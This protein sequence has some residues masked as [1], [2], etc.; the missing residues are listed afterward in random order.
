MKVNVRVGWE[1]NSS[2][3]HS[4][5]IT[6][7][8][9]EFT[10]DDVI[11]SW[12][13]HPDGRDKICYSLGYT[14]HSYGRAPFDLLTS[15]D[16][17]LSYI[18][19]SICSNCSRSEAD[20]RF[21]VIEDTVLE[22]FRKEF[23]VQCDYIKWDRT[24]ASRW[25]YV[26]TEEECK[27]I[28]YDKTSY[29]TDLGKSKDGKQIERIV[30][31]VPDYGGIEDGSIGLIQQFMKKYKVSIRDLLMKKRYAIVVDGDEYCIFDKIKEAGLIKTDNIIH[32]FPDGREE[33]EGIY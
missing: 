33:S 23:D 20:R 29:K 18:V 31:D 16:D 6:K 9:T 28:D 21:K 24:V 2:S 27:D 11:A 10:R 7:D 17:K 14:E 8:K 32:E 1:T 19:A 26:G 25:V 30:I 3:M 12:K 13:L 22:I 15:F 4:L 5:L